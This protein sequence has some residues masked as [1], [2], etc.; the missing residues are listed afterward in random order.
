MLDETIETRR[1]WRGSPHPCVHAGVFLRFMGIISTVSKP[2]RYSRFGRVRVHPCAR[3]LRP[4]VVALNVR[5]WVHLRILL[6]LL[7]S[8]YYIKY[9][10]YSEPLRTR[11]ADA[12]CLHVS[13]SFSCPQGGSNRA[14]PTHMSK[15]SCVAAALNV[16]G[17][18]VQRGP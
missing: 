2:L 3:G 5:I 13:S 14:T 4:Y 10:D 9:N 12:S 7:G 15:I 1:P 18:F 8:A 17:T 6:D 11:K 16:Q